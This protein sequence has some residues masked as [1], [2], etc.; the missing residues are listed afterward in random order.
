MKQSYQLREFMTKLYAQVKFANNNTN[1]TK[2][3]KYDK[4]YDW[5]QLCL[6]VLR[7]HKNS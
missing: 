2:I 1:T 3:M 4:K 7:I 6:F 5:I